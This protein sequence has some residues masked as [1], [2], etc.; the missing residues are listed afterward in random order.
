MSKLLEKHLP[1]Y[2]PR[3]VNGTQNTWICKPSYNA[4]GLGIFCFNK[5]QDIIA[6]FCKKAPAPKVVQ[7]YIERPLLIKNLNP[8]D[9]SDLRKFDIRQW[10]LLLAIEPTAAEQ[11]Q[12]V[13]HGLI[14]TPYP[15][16]YVYKDA[17][18]RLCGKAFDVSKLDDLQR[19]LS[20]FSIQKDFAKEANSKARATQAAAPGTPLD[21][22][23]HAEYKSQQDNAAGPSASIQRAQD[24]AQSQEFVMSTA[25]FID[26]L[27]S[28]EDYP[29][30]KHLKD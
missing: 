10:V 3:G 9:K 6:T 25:D 13:K 8:N 16:V 28:D 27:N 29:E 22:A 12:L 4:R 24:N 2:G 21:E 7:K 20:N 23:E 14:A 30:L 26:R 15:Q 19:H 1:Q 5:R 18:L 11:E 17:Y